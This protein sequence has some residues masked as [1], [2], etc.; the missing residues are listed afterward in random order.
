MSQ[1]AF[2]TIAST[3]TGNHRHGHPVAVALTDGYVAGLLAGAVI[4]TVGA[5]VAAFAIDTR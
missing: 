1:P 4:Y 2:A 5:A 3:V